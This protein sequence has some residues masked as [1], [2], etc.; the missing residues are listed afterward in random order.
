TTN[1]Y[2]LDPANKFVTTYF[3]SAFSVPKNMTV[4]NLNF[5]LARADGAAVWLNGQELFRT[6]LSGGPLAY[7]NLALRTMTGFTS[8]IYYPTNI[9]IVNSLAGTNQLAVELHLNSVT[10]PTAQFDMEVFASGNL[11]PP[12]TLSI[13]W[14]GGH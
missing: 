8:H 7:T 9:A 2:G 1:S 13:V 4:T 5:R 3:H 12:P 10:N 11:I 6:N 14:S